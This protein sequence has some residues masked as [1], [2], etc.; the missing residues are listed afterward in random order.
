MNEHGLS[1]A[2][3][4]AIKQSSAWF[5]IGFERAALLGRTIDSRHDALAFIDEQRAAGR[6]MPLRNTEGEQAMVAGLLVANGARIG[7]AS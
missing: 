6:Y 7:A 4:Q 2:Q 5:A 1:W 3:E